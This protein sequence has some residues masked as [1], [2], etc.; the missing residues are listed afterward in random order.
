MYTAKE[1]QKDTSVNMSDDRKKKRKL[2]MAD[3]Q[4]SRTLEP[5]YDEDSKPNP[6][7]LRKPE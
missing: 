5:S 3:D 7:M 4:N 1:S 2:V 6:Q